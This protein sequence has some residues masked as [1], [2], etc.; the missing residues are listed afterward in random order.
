[1]G[2][3]KKGTS[4]FSEAVKKAMEKM[5]PQDNAKNTEDLK[6]DDNK[7]HMEY[8]IGAALSTFLRIVG[9]EKMGNVVREN[10]RGIKRESI[11][12]S[13]IINKYFVEK[14]K[15]VITKKD[16]VSWLMDNEKLF[17]EKFHIL[18]Q[19]YR[20]ILQTIE[21]G[22]VQVNVSGNSISEKAD[23]IKEFA[24]NVIASIVA[25]YGRKVKFPK[26]IEDTADYFVEQFFCLR[27]EIR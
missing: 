8:P 11:E 16:W 6:H 18:P 10:L 2:K 12:L 24:M 4:N 19:I 9:E 25:L 26:R 1:M 20:F 27:K 14:G 13:E 3:N 7:E 22:I 5:K 21:E 17:F 15:E 23:K